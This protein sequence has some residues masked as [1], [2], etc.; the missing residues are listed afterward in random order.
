MS[1]LEA[2]PAVMA[3]R[4]GRLQTER[5]AADTAAA[6]ATLSVHPAAAP[7]PAPPPAHAAHPAPLCLSNRSTESSRSG[8][9]E[10][11]EQDEGK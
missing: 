3:A 11:M 1:A 6:M 9:E 5:D 7:A 2:A 4:L 8:S 10:P